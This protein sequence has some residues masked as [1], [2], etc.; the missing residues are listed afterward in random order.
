[1]DGGLFLAYLVLRLEFHPVSVIETSTELRYFVG[2]AAPRG[3][4]D[5]DPQTAARWI[6][7]C[8]DERPKKR[9]PALDVE[10]WRRREAELIGELRRAAPGEPIAAVFP[11]AALWLE[12]TS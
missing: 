6:R 5:V 12:P 9:S 1:M 7:A 2:G 3:I 11:I 10:A 4:A 8:C